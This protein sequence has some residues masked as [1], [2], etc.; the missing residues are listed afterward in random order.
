MTAETRKRPK[1]WQ[2][3]SQRDTANL[4]RKAVF[5]AVE[6]GKRLEDP[7]YLAKLA[8]PPLPSEAA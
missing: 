4:R 2:N 3:T 8:P 6:N 1:F 5:G 7:A